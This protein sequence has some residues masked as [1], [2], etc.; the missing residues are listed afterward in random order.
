MTKRIEDLDIDK[1]ESRH[2]I[3]LTIGETYIKRTYVDPL[4]FYHDQPTTFLTPVK[5]LG[6]PAG[7]TSG[8]SCMA[9][10]GEVADAE[11]CGRNKY[12]IR[13]IKVI[14][15]IIDLDKVCEEQG[16]EREYLKICGT[17]N[18]RNHELENKLTSLYGKKL[19]EKRIYGVRYRSR[20]DPTGHCIVLY[21]TLGS[22]K[23]YLSVKIIE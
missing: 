20:R 1:I 11:S 2:L 8:G 10:S 18:G 9:T 7:S 13:V 22:L 12:E 23:D 14:E 16:I 3:S 6:L 19:E 17:S 4:A 21:D 5:E 15:R